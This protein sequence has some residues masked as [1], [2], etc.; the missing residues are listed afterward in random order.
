MK[1]RY[2]M[3]KF[4]TSFTVGISQ[5]ALSKGFVLPIKIDFSKT[6][7]LLISAPSGSGKTYALKFILKQ[8]SENKGTIYLCDFKG[9]DF[10]DMQEC[11]RYYKHQAVAEGLE[12]VFNELQERMKNPK[13]DNQPIYF[14]I[15]EWSGFLASMPKKQQEDFKQN[16]A[17]IL[18]LGRGV[19]I[20]VILSMQRADSSNFLSG[21]RDNFGNVLALGRLSKEAIRMLFPDYS[22]LIQPKPRGHGYLLVD[23]QP[24][25][26]I[27]IPKIRDIE[28]TNNTIEKALS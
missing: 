8:L 13:P 5:T 20:F 25:T 24:L 21:A 28:K 27:V 10:I 14:V 17:S 23:G 3:M 12:I 9:I 15:D 26:E 11:E 22:D 6:P 4:D 16:L 1:E 18:M 7:H 19:N 2:M